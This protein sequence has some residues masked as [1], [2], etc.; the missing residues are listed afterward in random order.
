M[1]ADS[2]WI[3]LALCAAALACESTVEDARADDPAASADRVPFAGTPVDG[4][5]EPGEKRFA[6]LWQLT[7]GGEN[8]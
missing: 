1:R 7:T 8:A 4:L 6:H 2:S 3:W 5:I